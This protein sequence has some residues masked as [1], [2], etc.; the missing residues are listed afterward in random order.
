[1]LS[2]KC[3]ANFLSTYPRFVREIKRC[4]KEIT[5]R[6]RKMENNSFFFLISADKINNFAKLRTSRYK[7]KGK[8]INT[9]V[10]WL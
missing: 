9:Q 2:I 7:Y 10:I 6:R 4:E 5:L 8:G 1:M 3:H